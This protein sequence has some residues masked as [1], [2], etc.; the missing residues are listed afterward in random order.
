VEADGFTHGLN[1]G[2]VGLGANNARGEIDNVAVQVLPPDITF[3]DTQDFSGGAAIGFTGDRTGSWTVSGGRYVAAPSVDG[4]AMSMIELDV[5]ALQAAS[6]LRVETTLSTEAMS[7][8]IFDQYGP[9]QFKFVAILAETDQVVIGHHTANR[10]WVHDA[11]AER[12]IE[13]GTDHDL[14]VSATGTSISVDLDGQAVLGHVFTALVVDGHFGLFS[15][16][17]AGSFDAITIETNDSEVQGYAGPI[18]TGSDAV[19]TGAVDTNYS[20]GPLDRNKDDSGVATDWDVEA[21][22]PANEE[23]SEDTVVPTYD[24]ESGTALSLTGWTVDTSR[25]D[26]EEDGEQDEGEQR[27]AARPTP[28]VGLDWVVEIG[29]PGDKASEASRASGPLKKK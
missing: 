8:V 3:A 22:R 7:G 18:E 10:G 12:P 13:A 29:D 6:V 26:P 9:E 28:A 14:R 24:P 4:A 21:F 17:G 20:G 11:I 27:T 19:S 2:M 15:H 25:T 1:E 16:N 23:E 5:E